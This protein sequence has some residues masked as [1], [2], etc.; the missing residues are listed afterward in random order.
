M[1]RDRPDP[2]SAPPSRSIF[3]G[4]GAAR[5][6]FAIL[7][8]GAAFAL[9]VATHA[10]IYKGGE[11]NDLFVWGVASVVGVIAGTV[12][13][14]PQYGKRARSLFIGLAIAAFLVALLVSVASRHGLRAPQVERVLGTVIGAIAARILLRRA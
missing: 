4:H 14:P 6:A 3:E 12:C 2:G 11:P 5:W 13:A 7:A 8:A 9:T 1:A 10:F